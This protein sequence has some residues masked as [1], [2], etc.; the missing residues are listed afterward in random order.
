MTSAVQSAI[1]KHFFFAA[2]TQLA[3]PM[4]SM[5]LR[6]HSFAAALPF[7]GDSAF[8]GDFAE[9]LS[10]AAAFSGDFS[11]S[12][13]LFSVFL[14]VSSPFSS[15][16]FAFLGDLAGDLERERERLVL[17]GSWP[18]KQARLNVSI[19]AS[20]GPVTCS[21]LLSC[22]HTEY[23]KSSDSWSWRPRVLSQVCGYKSTGEGMFCHTQLDSLKW[24]KQ[25]SM[26]LCYVPP[27]PGCVRRSCGFQIE[28]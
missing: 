9:P 16:C 12:A 10:V 19:T 8:L 28:S 4:P 11:F 27:T 20:H 23:K 13:F 17:R 15:A 18:L 22:R 6:A 7:A 26:R 24:V 2:S 14:E 3:V 25:R 1:Q 5:L 21:W